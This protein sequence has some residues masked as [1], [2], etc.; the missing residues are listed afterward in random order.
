ML[1]SPSTSTPSTRKKFQVLHQDT[2]AQYSTMPCRTKTVR[3]RT[4]K[5]DTTAE[6]RR[7]ND[8]TCEAWAL[9]TRKGLVSG[10]STV[11][12]K[13]D[14]GDSPHLRVTRPS[15]SSNWV[16]NLLQ[17]KKGRSLRKKLPYLLGACC[18]SNRHKYREAEN[19][20]AEVRENVRGRERQTPHA[21]RISITPPLSIPSVMRLLCCTD[22]G[23]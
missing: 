7:S 19:A 14:Q 9:I 6:V 1:T 23:A 13:E 12:L 15:Q 8:L 2:R 3:M 10:A 21:L 20:K 5:P 17:N 16:A 18:A 4:R 11:E 22:R